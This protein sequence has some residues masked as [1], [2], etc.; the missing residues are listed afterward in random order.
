MVKGVNTFAG[1]TAA[2]LVTSV[3]QTTSACAIAHLDEQLFVSR[4]TTTAVSV[5]NTTSFQLLRQITT[6]VLVYTYLVWQ[7]IIPAITF[8]YPTTIISVYTELIYR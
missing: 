2:T 7:Q 1:F 4:C 6:L 3:S 8:T 5:Y